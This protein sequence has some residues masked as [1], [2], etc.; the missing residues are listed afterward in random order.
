MTCG[1]CVFS[2]S[3]TSHFSPRDVAKRTS[4]PRGPGAPACLGREGR[5]VRFRRPQGRREG[6]CRNPS[7]Q[8]KKGGPREVRLLDKNITGKWSKN[9]LK[10]IQIPNVTPKILDALPFFRPRVRPSDLEKLAFRRE[11]TGYTM[12]VTQVTRASRSDLGPL[13]G[14]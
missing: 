9:T 12:Q 5:V 13:Q 7:P 2:R 10:N 4:S 6:T 3:E 1:F 14:S 11:G 8:K